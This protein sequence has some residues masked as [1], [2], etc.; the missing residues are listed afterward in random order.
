MNS[1]DAIKLM[2]DRNFLDKIYGF[3]YR[4]CRTSHEAED[5]CSD[6]ILA[7]LG[8][9]KNQTEIESLH[10]LV[11]TVARRVYADHCRE[12]SRG[13][14]VVELSENLEGRDD[15]EDFIE[16]QDQRDRLRRIF[17]EI[18]FL[19]K[20]Y[21][22]VMV[23]YYLDEMKVKDIASRLG[24]LE[25]TVKQR[26]FSARNTVKKEI[27]TMNERNL[28]LKPVNLVFFGTGSPVGNDARNKAERLF[29]Q[30]LVYLCKDRP[31]TAKELSEELCVPMPYVEEE[32]DIQCKGENGSYGLLRKLEGDRYITNV[33]LVDYEEYD[34]ANKIYERYMPEVCARVRTAIEEKRAEIESLPFL[35]PRREPEFL[36][37]S[38]INRCWYK[39]EGIVR[40]LVEKRFYADIRPADRP[41]TA[42]AIAVRPEDRPK[43]DFYGND[44]TDAAD[45]CG[46]KYVHME[47][48]YGKRLKQSFACW[49]NT[50]QNPALL[51]LLR[52]IG[53]LETANLSE[54]ERE[55]AAKAIEA[56]YVRKN[57]SVLEPNVIV[58]DSRGMDDFNA[59]SS[60]LADGLDD[61]CEKIADDLGAFMKKR[62]PAHLTAEYRNYANLIAG[63]RG[64]S[65]LTEACLADGLLCQPKGGEGIVV[66]VRRNG[67]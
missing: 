44:G 8:A 49:E 66:V 20:S 39:I 57:G 59:L 6:I 30:N 17:K 52:S 19:S 65:D 23:M 12:S 37:W 29:S 42:V 1:A 41:F 58:L 45:V 26:L 62:L 13:A 31:R 4:R 33:V 35:G 64:L 22:D 53:G 28:T 46:Y 43:F 34:S 40:G 32:L 50:S 51:M 38:M 54:S 9:V 21:R 67:E 63:I 60:S 3:A 15:I 18:T 36:L 16:G 11:W 27:E 25:T 47:N 24:L 14:E 2:E 61:I 5:L 48:R 55:S 56:G 7:A 10:A